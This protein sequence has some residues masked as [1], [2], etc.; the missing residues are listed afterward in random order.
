MNPNSH[1]RM[2]RLDAEYRAC[3]GLP[4]LLRPDS[5][6]ACAAALART[7]P[8]HPGRDLKGEIRARYGNKAVRLMEQVLLLKRLMDKPDGEKGAL[9]ADRRR[10]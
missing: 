3:T 6:S 4:S 2:M 1:A 9:I 5:A 10:R 7:A 8:K